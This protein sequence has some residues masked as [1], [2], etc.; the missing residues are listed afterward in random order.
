M[1]RIIVHPKTALVDEPVYIRVTGLLP[2]QL[3]VLQAK[4]TN[5]KGELFFS[6]AFYK[7]DEGGEIDL[8]HAAA[9]GGDYLGIHPMGLFWSLK[10]EKTF[11]RLLKQDVMNSPFLV[12]LSVCDSDIFFK[13]SPASVKASETVERWYS[14]PG[15][16]RIQIRE[17]RIR[18]ILFIPPGEGPFPGVIDL[19]GFIGGLIE[20]RASLLASRGFATLALAYFDYEDLPKRSEDVDVE[21][22]EEAADFLLSHPKVLGPSI[23]VV[24]LSQGAQVGLAMAV[25]LK[26]VAATVCISGFFFSVGCIKYRNET[27]H[28][29]NTFPERARINNLGLLEIHSML[30]NPQ[31]EANKHALLPVERAQGHIL[32]IV[33][34]KDY[35]MNSKAY[36]EQAME[37]LRRHG[38]SNGTLLS[39]PGAGHLI[40]P[41]YSPL[42]LASPNPRIRRPVFWGGETVLHAEAQEHS[43]KEILKFLRRHLSP[44]SISKL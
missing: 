25:F 9:L 4:V 8:E 20:F 15:V 32:F 18:G 37:Q 1:V 23:G 10:S 14:A 3:V 19:F 28:S 44:G 24:S 35:N 38:K 30:G 27:I 29:I 26:Q 41:P 36:A 16:Q 34:E 40:E 42:C 5:E 13:D 17:G 39:Y 43:W 7:A 12:Q 33:G 31:E 2:N 22:F 11:S 21:Y 6:E